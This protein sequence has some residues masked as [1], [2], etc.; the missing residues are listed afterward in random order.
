MANL[1]DNARALV[2][3]PPARAPT[4]DNVLAQQR[5]LNSWQSPACAFRRLFA[6]ASSSRC[7][8]SCWR[9]AN[10]ICSA[11][12]TTSTCRSP[13]RT[14][15]V[16]TEIHAPDIGAHRAPNQDE[17]DEWVRPWRRQTRRRR[18]LRGGF[19]TKPFVGEMGRTEPIF[20]INTVPAAPFTRSQKCWPKGAVRV[21]AHAVGDAAIDLV[22]DGY[23]A[24]N[25]ERSIVGRR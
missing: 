20:G 13:R 6:S 25:T 19:M 7:S 5:T 8:I 3:L 15:V 4:M 18:R 17:G 12:A 22:L 24:A 16:D 21:A 23:E 10:A 9:H 11:F 2:T 14:R 1:V